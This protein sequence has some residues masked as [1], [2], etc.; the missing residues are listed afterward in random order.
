MHRRCDSLEIF[1]KNEKKINYDTDDTIIESSL[2]IA[3]VFTIKSM[4][5]TT[6]FY[7]ET[8]RNVYETASELI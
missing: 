1:Y 5:G 4:V 8:D 7:C 6:D 3:R 2:P